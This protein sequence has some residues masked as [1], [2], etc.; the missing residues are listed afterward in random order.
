MNQVEEAK[1]HL[2]KANGGKKKKGELVLGVNTVQTVETRVCNN[3][4]CG[5][6]LTPEKSWCYT[7]NDCH[8]SGFHRKDSLKLTPDD[9]KKHKEKQLQEQRTKFAKNKDN[10]GV[11]KK[12]RKRE[13]SFQ[14]ST[15]E[16]DSD[17]DGE[18]ENSDSN[19]NKNQIRTHTCSSCRDCLHKNM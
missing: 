18:Y 2:E 10:K 4:N 13:K 14:A 12:G 5:V 1:D 7:F 16:V 17:N 6:T 8:K 3:P 9:Q 19:K 11:V 15:V